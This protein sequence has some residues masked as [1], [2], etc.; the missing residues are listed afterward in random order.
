MLKIQ[1]FLPALGWRNV[2]RDFMSRVPEDVDLKVWLKW[3]FP[4]S[5]FRIVKVKEKN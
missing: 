3:N 4:A 5:E 2:N 1:I